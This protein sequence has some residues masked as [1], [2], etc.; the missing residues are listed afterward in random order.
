MRN[1]IIFCMLFLLAGIGFGCSGRETDDSG[2]F[3]A[4]SG[5]VPSRSAP[6]FV[7]LAKKLQPIVVNVSTTQIASGL[8]PGT[9]SDQEENPME[10]FLERYFGQQP[11][12]SRGFSAAE[13]GFGFYYWIRRFNC[14]KCPR[15]REREKNHREAL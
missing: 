12:S 9:Q 3:L 14:D 2:G 10:E 5:A 15:G 4:K 7:T 11:P 1:A 13:S 6:D 8:A